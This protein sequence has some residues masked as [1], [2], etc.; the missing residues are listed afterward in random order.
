MHGLGTHKQHAGMTNG[1]KRVHCCRPGCWLPAA[2]LLHLLQAC[3]V[4]FEPVYGDGASL[5]APQH[6]YLE[7]RAPWQ[8]YLDQKL[9]RDK[10]LLPGGGADTGAVA[11]SMDAAGDAASS[12][13]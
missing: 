10:L 8:A 9:Q 2:L 13:Q 7:R 3:G 4:P 5:S 6:A 12:K 11:G 1:M